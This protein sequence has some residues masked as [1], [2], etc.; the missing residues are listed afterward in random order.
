ME[1]K[2][3]EVGR[4]NLNICLNQKGNYMESYIG[5]KIIKAT[6]MT[7]LDFRSERDSFERANEAVNNYKKGNNLYLKTHHGMSPMNACE[8]NPTEKPG[9]KVMYPDGYISW[10]PKEQFEIA[11]R[12][13][14]QNEKDL[15]G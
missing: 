12:E 9:Y 4:I 6:P 8:E 7:D 15:I 14:T 13:I 1:Q 2:Q 5:T 10:S 11:Y 3:N